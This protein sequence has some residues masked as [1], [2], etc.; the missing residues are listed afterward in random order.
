[1]IRWLWF[2]TAITEHDGFTA[3]TCVRVTTITCRRADP[4][5]EPFD[6]ATSLDSQSNLQTTL[7]LSSGGWAGTNK[8]SIHGKCQLNSD[9]LSVGIKDGQYV[10]V[11][12]HVGGVDEDTMP[13]TRTNLRC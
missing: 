12:H 2:Q 8:A 6:T 10:P 7:S 3:N 9:K 5:L 11:Y 13:E 4:F 1:M